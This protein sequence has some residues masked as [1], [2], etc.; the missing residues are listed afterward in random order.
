MLFELYLSFFQIGSFSFGG[1]LAALSLLHQVIIEQNGWLTMADFGNL[2]SIAEIT[3]GPIAINSASFVGMKLSGL[4]GTLA[5]TLGFITP[6]VIIV[7]ILALIYTKYGNLQIVKEIL[8][9]LRLTVIALLATAGLKIS[10]Q[11]FFWDQTDISLKGLNILNLLLFLLA[12]YL[13]RKKK[14]KPIL[15][16]LG[17][18]FISIIYSLIF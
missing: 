10:K 9:Y 13:I 12:F 1:G 6:S 18:G 11:A 3:P 8:K 7:S 2:V 4:A 15:A 16:I 17:C 5:A 14:L